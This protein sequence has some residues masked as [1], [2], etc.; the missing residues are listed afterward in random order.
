MRQLIFRILAGIL[1]LVFGIVLSI[2]DTSQMSFRFYV[3]SWIIGIGF[4][5]FAILGT[6]IAESFLAI[7]FGMETPKKNQISSEAGEAPL[8]PGP[9][10]NGRVR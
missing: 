6:Q 9:P 2:G 10:T 7:I 8:P 4:G 5:L 3:Y 1:S